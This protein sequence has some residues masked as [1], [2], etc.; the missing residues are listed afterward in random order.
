MV[1]LLGGFDIVG[2]QGRVEVPHSAARVVAYL[3]IQ[4]HP[5]PR[6]AI[7]SAIWPD[8]DAVRG[9]A[10]LRSTMSRI[11]ALAPLHVATTTSLALSPNVAVDIDDLQ[12]YA[13]A[14]RDSPREATAP[15]SGFDLEF[16][17][18]WTEDWVELERERLRQLGLH[19]LDEV[20]C[21]SIRNGRPGDGVDAALR[22]I[23]LD[24]LR[25]SS[26]AGLLRALLAGG[27]RAA[28]IAHFRRVSSLM[29]HELGL[30]PSG[31]LTALIEEILPPRPVR[32]S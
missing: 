23:R 30:P 32:R 28:A 19:L 15:P 2:P 21:T 20:V 31:D 1:H 7:A 3:A 8:I 13:R 4:G 18:G 12:A 17:P 10:N 27:N 22:A 25:E 11:G 29:R 26:H 6:M 9:R 16:L 14:S 24:P 5:V